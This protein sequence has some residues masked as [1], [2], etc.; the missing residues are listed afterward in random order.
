MHSLCSSAEDLQKNF[1]AVAGYRPADPPHCGVVFTM[2]PGPKEVEGV[3]LG[4]HGLLANATEEQ[5]FVDT[6]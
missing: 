1:G 4:A 5:L 6:R 2:L 3:Y